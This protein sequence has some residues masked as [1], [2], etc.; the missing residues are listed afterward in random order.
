M[1]KPLPLPLRLLPLLRKVMMV[2]AR[3]VAEVGVVRL[4]WQQV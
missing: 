4:Q 1:R 2:T 3:A